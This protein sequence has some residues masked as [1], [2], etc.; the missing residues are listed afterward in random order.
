M[1]RLATSPRWCRHGAAR[2]HDDQRF[3]GQI[4]SVAIRWGTTTALVF[5]APA[6]RISGPGRDRPQGSITDQ[7]VSSYLDDILLS[8][9]DATA[10][11]ARIDDCQLERSV[12]SVTYPFIWRDKCATRVAHFYPL[13]CTARTVL[14]MQLGPPTGAQ[15]ALLYTRNSPT[16]ACTTVLAFWHRL[17]VVCGHTCSQRSLAGHWLAACMH[18]LT[19]AC[20]PSILLIISLTFQ[21][22]QQTESKM[23]YSGLFIR[24]LHDKWC[25]GPR[26]LN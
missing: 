17:Q 9:G 19:H 13:F 15:S 22:E 25:A 6:R 8:L 4:A 20:L 16:G 5:C 26:L 1:A 7:P 10:T 2:G 24:Q 3:A 14:A 12:F 21:E 23:C 18:V 11:V